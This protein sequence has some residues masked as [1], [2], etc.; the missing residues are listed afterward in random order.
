M[1]AN[2]LNLNMKNNGI[3]MGFDLLPYDR[4]DTTRAHGMWMIMHSCL[5]SNT[6]HLIYIYIY[7]PS[8]KQT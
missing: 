8:G 2:P 5:Q 6:T 1:Y 3:I 7:V 4:M